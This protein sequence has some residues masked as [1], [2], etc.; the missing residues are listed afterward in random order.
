M[1]VALVPELRF[2]EFVDDWEAKIVDN[3]AQKIGSGVTPKGGKQSY[4]DEG[5][6]LIR[7]QN[8]NRDTV[9]LDDVAFISEATHAA[10]SNSHVEDGDILLN[11]T[12]AS[13]GRS[14]LVSTG[15]SPANVNQH[16]CIIRLRQND[17]A[18]FLQRL[19][20]AW[21]G[22][23]E[24]FRTQAGGGREGLNFEA[25]KAFKFSFPSLPE[26]KKIA[27]FLGAVDEKLKALRAK[28]DLLTDYKRGCMQQLFTQKIRFKRDNGADFPNWEEKKLGAVAEFS[29]GKGLSKADISEYGNTSCIRYAELY[30]E[31]GQVIATT[32][33][34]TN[35]PK[36]E[37]SLSEADDV[38]IPASGESSVDIATAACVKNGGVALG[39]DIN[40]IRSNFVGEYLARY[41]THHKNLDIARLA[42]G[43]SVVHLYRSHLASLTVKFPHPDEQ[44]KIANFLS[45]IDVKINTVTDQISAVE[46]F[47]KGLLQ[48]MFV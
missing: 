36:S 13:I 35:I 5:I 8:V 18:A 2:P 26:Q 48:Q 47:K 19:I 45:T 46:A 14:A 17:N 15:I 28:K 23:R 20:S 40:I 31:Y 7:S 4:L 9:I 6:P 24:I 37:L 29:K 43:N 44:Q 27:A 30:T 22:Q 1:S 12:G 34:S 41:L 21:Q 33:S 38:I 10:M 42:Q 3:I 32:V 25:I 11:I 16:V 39:G